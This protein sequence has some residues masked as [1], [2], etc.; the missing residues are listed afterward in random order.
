MKKYLVI[1][2]FLL[3]PVLVSAIETPAPSPAIKLEQRIGL[4][5]FTLEYSRPGVKERQIFGGLVP[6]DK[7]WRTGANASTKLTISEDIVF[8]GQDV[9]AG[10]YGLYTIPGQDMWTVILSTNTDLWGAGGYTEEED[11]VR[12]KVKPEMTNHKLESMLITF[13]HLRNDSAEL[14]LHWDNVHVAVPILLHTKKQVQ[15]NISEAM[16]DM[17]SWEGG[18]YAD[19][20]RAYHA[21]GIDNEKSLEWINKAI[22]SN[23]EAFWLVYAK[24]E[25]LVSLDRKEEATAAAEKSHSLAKAAGNEGYVKRNEELLTKLR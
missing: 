6:Y 5:D 14:V 2:L 18:D 22:E 3:C 25:I 16:K 21:Y 8:G 7:V 11:A 19:A 4:T 10:E 17:D 15:A 20:A 12:V 9:A 13:D 23:S 24:A 1:A